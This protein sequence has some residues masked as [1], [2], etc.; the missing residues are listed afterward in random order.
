MPICYLCVGF[1]STYVLMLLGGFVLY[2]YSQSFSK[3]VTPRRT[4][5]SMA[6]VFV[7]IIP[8]LESCHNAH[9]V[10]IRSLIPCW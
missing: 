9:P 4:M 7:V 8:F 6:L 5:K 3:Y 2:F 1:F 10:E